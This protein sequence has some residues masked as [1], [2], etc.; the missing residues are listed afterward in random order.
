MDRA[1]FE[2]AC[3]P[4]GKN[5]LLACIDCRMILTQDQFLKKRGC[6][7][8]DQRIL[9]YEGL[10]EY[11]T[12]N[13]SGM[14]SVLGALSQQ[15]SWVCRWNGLR[16]CAPGCY[17]IDARQ[18]VTMLRDGAQLAGFEAL[19][20]SENEYEEESGRGDTERDEREVK[21]KRELVA[22]R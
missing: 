21:I 22:N 5:K 3:P 16:K 13:F 7:N 8:C 6:P 9:D 17:A 18:E 19:G 2:G 20:D 1:D 15:S 11:T 4:D 14:I 12:T 10:R